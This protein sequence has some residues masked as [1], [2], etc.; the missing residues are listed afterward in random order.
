MARV[1]ALLLIWASLQILLRGA[2]VSKK[3]K[4]ARGAGQEGLPFAHDERRRGGFVQVP[5][6]LIGQVVL[7]QA[8]N[9]SSAPCGAAGCGGAA[10]AQVARPIAVLAQIAEYEDEKEAEAETGRARTSGE[11]LARLTHAMAAD[12]EKQANW[13][14][15][16]GAAR[17]AERD[18][19]TRRDAHL[20]PPGEAGLPQTG[21]MQNCLCA[22]YQRCYP[23]NIPQDGQPGDIDVGVCDLGL[24]SMVLGSMVI[25]ALLVVAVLLLRFCL[26]V[27]DDEACKQFLDA[28]PFAAPQVQIRASANVPPR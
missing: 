24:L 20:C 9:H 7:T 1:A 22:W 23:N 21:C 4:K 5:H 12:S 26:I 8:M 14:T 28:K 19:P 6:P 13:S 2:R 18:G 15:D 16:A 11:H 17:Q 25:F 10:A 27:M 3:S